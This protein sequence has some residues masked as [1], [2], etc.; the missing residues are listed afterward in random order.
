MRSLRIWIPLLCIVVALAAGA[1]FQL[2][3]SDDGGRQRPIAVGTT[4]AVGGLDPA[5][6]YDT[7]S[8]ALYSNLFQSLLTLPPGSAAPVPDAAE[9]CRFLDPSLTTYAC[10]LREGLTF[11]NGHPLTAQDVRHSFKRMLGIATDL[12]PASLFSGLHR[13]SAHGRTVTFGLR[14]QD[15]TFP[16]KLA[17]GA[18]AIVDRSRYPSNRLRPGAAVD[19]SGPYTLAAYTPDLRALLKPNPRYQGAVGV[20][21][22]PIEVRY[23]QDSEHLA[24]AWRRGDVEVA[25]RQLPSN[26]TASYDPGKETGR[27]TEAAGAEIRTL[28]FDLRP[29][30]PMARREVRQ[31][32]AVLVDRGPITTHVHHS[33]VEPLY[34][35]IPQ[36]LAGHTTSFFDRYHRDDDTRSRARAML[37]DAGVRTP[38]A[39]TYGHREGAAFAAE[40][41]ELRRQLEATGMF[42]VRTV[43]AEWQKFQKG[44][45]GGAYD[46]YGL[47][48]V[49]D[50]PDPDNF[51][52]PLVGRANALHNTYANPRIDQLISLTQRHDD[53]RKTAGT[54]REIQHVIAVDVPVLPL[55]QR[56]DYVL[57]GP[58]VA[59]S[60]HLS[61]G[62]GVWRLWR[63]SPM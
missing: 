47:S 63:L 48:W 62:T 42:R 49:P 43:S 12:G 13:V 31:A 14:H 56:K 6:S 37:R 60:E 17:T 4:D 28:V 46:A 11:A 41:A 54:F 34:S 33:T 22:G 19:G 8:W 25:H 32:I 10:T 39:F 24:T 35:L 40:A 44:Y 36:G 45:A 53:R 27:M 26:L 50:F 5:G 16:M 2:Q 15:A 20:P 57:A 38:V 29:G 1:G 7:G 23:F 30:S 51:T 21:R 61:D 59:G 9:S 58:G 18:G 52:T 3:Q 55:W